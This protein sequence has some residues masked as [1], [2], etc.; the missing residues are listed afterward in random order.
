MYGECPCRKDLLSQARSLGLEEQVRLRGFQPNVRDF[1]PGYRAH[2]H[3]AYSES[4]SLAIIEAMGARLPIVAG[5]LD[6]LAELCDDGGGPFFPLGH[7]RPC[8]G[9]G[10]LD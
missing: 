8:R 5:Y 3:A 1:L 2:V 10:D 9:G 6:P 7:S 4:S